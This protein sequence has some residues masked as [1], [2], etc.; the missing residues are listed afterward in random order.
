MSLQYKKKEFLLKSRQMEIT[1]E[2]EKNEITYKTDVKKV[3]KK[4]NK[5]E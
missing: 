5:R 4:Q 2:R 1:I 3:K